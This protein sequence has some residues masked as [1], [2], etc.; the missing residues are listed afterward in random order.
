MFNYR[1]TVI[2]IVITLMFTLMSEP[3]IASEEKNGKIVVGVLSNSKDDNI[4][5]LEAIYGISLDYLFNISSFLNLKL[6]I[7]PYTNIPELLDDVENNRIDGA[8]G[9]SRTDEREKKFAFSEPI[10]STTLAI[11]YRDAYLRN[12]QQDKLTWACVD[13]SVYCQ[14]I[15]KRG[16]HKLYK[17]KSRDD[18]FDAVLLGKADA[19]VSTYVSINEYLDHN[20]VMRG[21]VDVPEWLHEEQVRFISSKDNQELIEQI[22]SI[23]LWEIEGLGIRSVASKNLYH[24]S[25]K[26]I[27]QYK[28]D[29]NGKDV[30]TY[31]SKGEAYP[32]F[33]EN[34]K[35]HLDGMLVEYLAL[36]SARTGL[37]FDYVVPELNLDSGYTTF[38]A[39]V[40]PVLYSDNSEA[41]AAQWLITKPF[42]RAS[43]TKVTR[44]ESAKSSKAKKQGILLSVSKQGIINVGDREDNNIT[45]YRDMKQILDDLKSDKI[46]VAYIPDDITYSMVLNNSTE[47][48]TFNKKE[49]VTYSIAFAVSKK[50]FELKNV[51][52]S[53]IDTI[54]VEEI[55]KLRRNYRKFDLI[56]G[57]DSSDVNKLA[58]VVLVIFLTFSY[59]GYL[60]FTNLRYKVKLAELNAGHEEKERIWLSEII[61]E[62]NNIV[63]IHNENNEILLSNCPK[64]QTQECSACTMKSQATG[65]SLV[66]NQ[67][68]IKTILGGKSLKDTHLAKDCRLDISHIYRES[69]TI[70]SSNSNK[71]FIL[72]SLLDVSAQ[73][74]RENALIKA[75]KEASLAVQAKESLLTTMSHELRTPLSAVHGLLDIIKINTVHDQDSHLVDQAIRSLIHLNKLVD[76]VLDLS[77]IESG[78]L[79]VEA[80]KV[81]LLPLLCDVFRTFE[82][83][84]KSK[85]LDYNVEIQPFPFRWVMVDG[86]RVSQILTNLLSNAVKFTSEGEIRILAIVREDRLTIE[87]TDTGIGMTHCQQKRVLK[88]FVQADDTITRNFGGTGLGLS[89]V[90]QLLQCMGGELHIESEVNCGTT[91]KV[92]I[93]LILSGD[94]TGYEVRPLTYSDELPSN[95]K[96]WCKAWKL[97]LSN[98]EP[99]L[100]MNLNSISSERA[101]VV[102]RSVQEQ[103]VIEHE[104]TKYP[105]CLLNLILPLGELALEQQAS[106]VNG[107][108]QYSEVL[109][110]EDNPINQ[111]VMTLQMKELG[112][113]PVFVDT[114]LQAWEYINNNTVE[115]LLT[116]FH[117]P[118]MDGYEL[119][120]KIKSSDKFKDIVVIGITA[121][122]AR[123]AREKTKNI[124]IDDILYKPYS[125]SRLSEILQV[126]STPFVRGPHWLER[127]DS[128]DAI[129]VANV[130]IETMSEDI[131]LV[132]VT[133]PAINRVIH[134]I[135][136]ALNA[137]GADDIS[138]LCKE[139]ECC[140]PQTNHEKIRKL[141]RTI[142]SEIKR[143]K[144]WLKANEH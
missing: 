125:V 70:S 57:Y 127:F 117:M 138:A 10:F 12:K 87:L 64:F 114:G 111:S 134:R 105:D 9:F 59:V 130:F 46:S 39:D 30:I 72:T 94:S 126:H 73:Q 37:G 23:L 33:F 17:A 85:N 20:D 100:E 82:P 95:L 44:N 115:L 106:I 84:S 42:M 129:A 116:D 25:D 124:G 55:E 136:G 80:E 123:V 7:K 118:E 41:S 135:K 14:F 89:I 63:F 75:E 101:L 1:N 40:V 29:H 21:A 96:A 113:E 56:Y 51:L 76:G 6:D 93:P 18:A 83:I 22:D 3:T 79:S 62:I 68:E 131:V 54:S 13:Q 104:Q 141:V 90:D 107:D 60:I 26:L 133:S 98:D 132:D 112:I 139:V 110:A 140:E 88:P 77:K 16:L 27:S 34:E 99:D 43:F 74:K 65:G 48:L 49:G 36:L 142:E 119:V 28:S 45:R 69:K 86:T 92:S 91:I 103:A 11:W 121:E 71:R 19:L 102:R 143:T 108:W 24:V 120:R 66:G 128:D 61:Q 31:S 2:F 81:E 38:N 4:S 78:V 8:L 47:G 97:T 52:N 50:N 109:I 67:I 122:D 144:A 35:Q 15:E 58:A 53:I 32:F 137:I 5:S